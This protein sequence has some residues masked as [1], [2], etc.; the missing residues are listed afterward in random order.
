MDVKGRRV[1]LAETLEAP[2]NR[3]HHQEDEEAI[4]LRRSHRTRARPSRAFGSVHQSVDLVAQR[5]AAT[6]WLTQ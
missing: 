1:K 4:A 5:V 2:Q 3:R 6:N